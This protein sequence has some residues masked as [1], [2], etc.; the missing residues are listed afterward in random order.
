MTSEI[1]TN[2]L[3]SRAGMSTVT[4]T[5]SG[6]MFSG[7]TTFVDNSGFTFGVGGGTSIFTPATNVL[8][9]GTNNTEKIRIDA[10]GHMHGVGVITAT[11][12][13]GDGSNLTGITET[14]IN[15]NANNRLITGSGTANTLEGEANLTF[16]GQALTIGSGYLAVRKGS[17][18][19]VDIQNSTD[20]SYA[21]LYIAQSSGS[22]GY[23]AINK[24]GTNGGGYTGG[25]NA[26]QLWLSS[27]APMLFATNNAE[28]LRIDSSGRLGLGTNNPTKK[29]TVQAGANNTDIALF[30]GNDLNRGLL[31]STIAA[32]SQ[33]D[34][35]VVYHA[36]GQHGGSYLGE[37]IFK[38]NNTERLR[39]TSDGKFLFNNSTV[40]A[41][42]G[43]QFHVTN[44]NVALNSF[45][46]NPHA[47]TFMFAK[48]RGTSGSGGTIV[49][50]NDFCG[51]IEWYADDGVDTAN[52]IA[53]ISGRIDGTPGANNT[54]GELTFY[55]TATNANA[56]TERLR[57]ASNGKIHVKG[58]GG[59]SS[60]NFSDEGTFLNLKHDTYGGRI[61]FSNGTAS[62][63]IAIA[64]LFGYWGSNKVTG[65]LMQGGGDATNRDDGQM[66]F[67]TTKS[68][69]SVKER[70]HIGTEGQI[71]SGYRVGTSSV[72][73]NQPVAFHSANITPHGNLRRVS[74]GQR[75][76]LFVGSNTGWSSG[77]GGV[78]AMGGSETGGAGVEATWAYVTGKRQSGNGWEYAGYFEVGTSP[79]SGTTMAKRVRIWANGQIEIYP[80]DNTF[81]SSQIGGAQRLIMEH[82]GGGNIRMRNAS[83]GSVTYQTTSDYRLKEN[84]VNITNAL[85]T[86]KSLKPYEYKWKHDGKLGQGFF[87]HE[88]Q[89][90]LPDIGIVTGTKD[91]VHAE[92]ETEN[93]GQWKK[94]DPIYQSI[95]YSKLVP[96]LTASIQE[97][98]A[99]VESLEEQNIALRARITNLE[100]N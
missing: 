51:H 73:S 20:T 94:D 50:D 66:S 69:E 54:P 90:V 45:Y 17:L 33:N 8:T 41:T 65:W 28:R 3:K 77:D 91:E 67:Y 52:Q 36:H 62:A 1:R 86:V 15:N 48:S 40:T 35:G 87:A 39:I 47:Q 92:D 85:T 42:N 53:K 84:V 59:D 81:F 10:S 70:L 4:M 96:L 58:N 75:C 12:F 83:S 79:Y 5:D 32:N 88:A 9:F 72:R 74:T 38:T 60:T 43:G 13:Y 89:A 23:F 100:G 11:H 24:I 25:S 71:V 31:I 6:P 2:S 29:L 64:E 22:G 49:N 27:N 46:N 82:T 61:G 19:Q 56:S 99:K 98:S 34:M 57:I 37:H 26:A 95:D 97:L 63:G 16:D 76:N 18:P 78:I 21:R 68:G 80:T 7:I 93:G 30:T 14:T 55:T 44:T